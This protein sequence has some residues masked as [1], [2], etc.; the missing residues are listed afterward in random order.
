MRSQRK[1]RM[2][3]QLQWLE[4]LVDAILNALAR[5]IGSLV[6]GRR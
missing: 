1:K 3:P 4:D 6:P 5:I 2:V